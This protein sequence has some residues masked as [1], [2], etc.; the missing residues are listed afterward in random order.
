MTRNITIASQLH[1]IEN[2]AYLIP[3]GTYTLGLHRWTKTGRLVPI[4]KDVPA[5]PEYP[6]ADGHTTGLR[7]Y[8]LIHQGTKPEHSRGCILAP[9][10][11]VEAL[12]TLIQHGLTTITIQ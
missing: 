2:P 5:T 10:P 6:S 9:Q 8:I 1:T 12:V 7:S 4:L 11:V 3:P